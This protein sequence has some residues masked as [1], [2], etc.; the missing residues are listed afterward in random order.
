M[1][2]NYIAFFFVCIQLVLSFSD[3]KVTPDT[4]CGKHGYVAQLSNHFECQCKDGFA[5][6]K[7]TTCKEV[8]KC[9]D[10]KASKNSVCTN[11]GKCVENTDTSRAH[12]LKSS[13]DNGSAR[14]DKVLTCTCDE[15]YVMKDNV[16]VVNEC[17]DDTVD[18][19]G[20][21][22]GKCVLY[23]GDKKEEAAK[24]TCA[25][26]IGWDLS[27]EKKCTVEQTDAPKCALKCGKKDECKTYADGGFIACAAKVCE[28]GCDGSPSS[29]TTH[30]ISV[31]GLLSLLVIY[32]AM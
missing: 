5:L 13:D 9:D 20:V 14:K 19:G 30:G 12:N 24:T 8:F 10:A 17:S 31:L 27:E 21:E 22:K 16:C 1:K 29:S 3:A 11:Y 32:M 7:E 26:K 28:D 4:K 6:E 15:G 2:M 25:C 23:E 18:C